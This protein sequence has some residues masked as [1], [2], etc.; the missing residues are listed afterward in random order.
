VSNLSVR[1]HFAAGHRILGLDGPGAKCRNPHGHTWFATWTFAQDACFPPVIEFGEA[2]AF[3]REMVKSGWDHSFIVHKDDVAMLDF[4][5]TQDCKRV[6]TQ[7][8]PTTEVVAQMLALPVQ[9][10]FT[11]ARLL[12][13]TV[14]EG[15]ENSATWEAV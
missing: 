10:R 2:K 7:L 14:E 6:V 15:P 4:L 13:V 3:I 1:L 9:D 8:P 12:S 11:R 5:T